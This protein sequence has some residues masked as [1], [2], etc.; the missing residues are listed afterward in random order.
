[1]KSKLLYFFLL[2]LAV[3]LFSDGN[4]ISAAETLPGGIL[5]A[6]KDEVRAKMG[7]PTHYYIEEHHSR[8]HWYFPVE[9]I[10]KVRPQ[11]WAQPNIP[12]DDVFPAEK[13]GKKF[14]YRV[15]YEWDKSQETQPV[16]RVTK[17]WVHFK[18][19][20]VTLADVPGLAP[21][22]DVATKPGVLVYQQRKVPSGEV[23]VTF[24]VPESSELARTISS[25][26]KPPVDDYEWSPSFQVILREGESEEISL[27][28]KVSELVITVDSQMRINKLARVFSIKDIAN[29]FPS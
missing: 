22:F 25:S 5:G 11:L 8:R 16:L 17:C 20:S 15:H 27:E 21:E 29:P 18:D 23:V 2:S 4:P 9:D 12:I 1:M 14:L 7:S 3:V 28:S 19:K 24:L 6:T 26:F 10:D 13:N